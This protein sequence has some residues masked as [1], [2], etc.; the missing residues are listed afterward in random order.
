MDGYVNFYPANP[1]LQSAFTSAMTRPCYLNIFLDGDFD[2]STHSGNVRATLILEA[3]IGTGPFRLHF[4]AV[5]KVVPYPHGYFSDFHYPM[6]RMCPNY[7]G[8]T[9]TFSGTY[10]ET[11][12]VSIPF[13]LDTT[14]WNYEEGAIYFAVWLQ[15]HG[16]PKYIHQS[17]KIDISGLNAVEETPSSPVLSDIFGL[18]DF[19]PN[20]FVGTAFIP[21]QISSASSVSLRIF[22]VSGRTVR[23]IAVNRELDSNTSFAWDGKDDSGREV[24]AGIYR[25]ELTSPDR[26][27]SKILIKVQ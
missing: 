25:V 21:V 16:S 3:S 24:S 1:N 7:N 5:S 20:P 18:G 15:T 27:D 13:T 26:N 23:T 19:Y 4:A 10:P 9:V 12:E 8:T 2:P 11:L 14:W 6:R 17:N 22:D